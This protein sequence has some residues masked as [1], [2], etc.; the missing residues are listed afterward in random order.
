LSQDQQP[1]GSRFAPRSAPERWGGRL[2]AEALARYKQ[3]NVLLT[4]F[5]VW[6]V[7]GLVATVAVSLAQGHTN[8]FLGLTYTA[9]SAL[10]G[11]L[12][13]VEYHRLKIAVA[14]QYQLT[15][16]DARRLSIWDAPSFDQS[17]QRVTN[18]RQDR[19]STR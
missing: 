5:L 13:L 16:R 1:S 18:A 10:L 17:L 15:K 12:A 2:S 14:K 6:G 4:V 3:T 11:V 9:V 7:A 19:P 8:Y